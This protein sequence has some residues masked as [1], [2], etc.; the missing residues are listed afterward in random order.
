MSSA[1]ETKHDIF[2]ID[3]QTDGRFKPVRKL[4]E[5]AM[6]SVWLVR[7]T[8]FGEDRAIKILKFL[9]ARNPILRSRFLREA[10]VMAAFKHPHVVQV[11]EYGNV[12][13]ATSEGELGL[14]YIVMEF[15]TGGN[16]EE[17]LDLAAGP[18]PPRFAITKIVC[19]ILKALGEAHAREI[20]HRDV[21]PANFLVDHGVIKLGDFGIAH[22]ELAQ[23][24]QGLTKDR[25]VL[26]T[27]LYMAPEQYLDSSK[28]DPRSDLYA[29]GMILWQ[30]LYGQK[31]ELP[32]VGTRLA[33][34]A[35]YLEGIPEVLH[36][37]LFRAMR[38]RPEDR[39]QTSQEFWQAL[40]EILP[41]LPEDP[42][43]VLPLTAYEDKKMEDRV[44]PEPTIRAISEIPQVAGATIVL[45]EEGQDSEVSCEVLGGNNSFLG[46][47]DEADSSSEAMEKRGTKSLWMRRIAL[48]VV[49]M[50]LTGAG[51]VSVRWW[52]ARSYMSE[53]LTE[54][55]LSRGG[56]PSAPTGQ[57]SSAPT[58]TPLV[59]PVPAP[60]IETTVLAPTEMSAPKIESKVK[61]KQ[62]KTSPIMNPPVA[63]EPKKA[64][65][66][67]SGDAKGVWLCAG[68]T[69]HTLPSDLDA[70]AYTIEAQFDEERIVVGSV[71]VAEGDTI[72]IHC[73]AAFARC[74]K[75]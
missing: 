6:G 71:V 41:L 4:G 55:S 66:E 75:K 28:A 5:G 58:E 72:T 14:P 53:P 63:E 20:V 32:L 45:P 37:V 40:E 9:V 27:L 19:P 39:F 15:I 2:L 12:R 64:H 49:L 25:E 11:Y 54:F 74:K 42:P 1:P 51:V 48:A 36:P 35:Q 10:R 57:R 33:Q 46:I 73:Q 65:A 52:L 8:M 43:D 16:L 30:A 29:A 17:Y 7:D 60:V 47:K 50:M 69:S 23:A 3:P 68:G 31:P 21:K 62:A 38:A 70:G 44:A 67:A 13:I 18:I 24:T 22:A 34:D 26:G 56:R 59:I 61:A